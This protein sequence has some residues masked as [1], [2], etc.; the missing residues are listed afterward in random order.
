MEAA[1]CLIVKATSWMDCWSFALKS[2]AL[3]S[4]GDSRLLSCLSLAGGSWWP[5]RPLPCGLILSLSCVMQSWRRW[6]TLSPL[7]PSWTSSMLGF[8]PPISSQLTCWRRL[9]W[10][11]LRS[12]TMRLS[13]KSLPRNTSTEWQKVAA[14]AAFSPAVATAAWS[15]PRASS[16]SSRSGKRKK[17]WKVPCLSHSRRWEAYS[18]TFGTPGI[19]STPMSGL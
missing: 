11:P 1:V 17:F 7:S 5:R 16:S 6:R 15:S 9:W 3:R 14:I 2:L 4:S 18:V 10:G 19:T 8:L 12:S 13:V